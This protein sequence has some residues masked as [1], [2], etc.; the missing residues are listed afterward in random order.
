MVVIIDYGMGNLHSIKRTINKFNSECIVSSKK[1]DIQKATKLILPGVGHFKTAINN[2]IELDLI[3]LLNS[4]VIENNVSILGI[5]L[6]AQLFSKFS[7]EGNCKG[8]GWIDAD[9]VKFKISDKLRFKIP[10]I[11]W[12]NVMIKHSNRLNRFISEDDQFYFVHSYHFN[13][14]DPSDIWMTSVYDY[15]FV[16]AIRCG[17]IYGTQFHPEK[18][19][20]VGC[21]LLKEFMAI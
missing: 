17:N 19:H 3:D 6:G 15:E 7:H 8:L 10:H 21:F 1:A 4:K 18:S 20:S 12:N 14:N 5:C 9:V 2:L 16:S 11:G 13:C